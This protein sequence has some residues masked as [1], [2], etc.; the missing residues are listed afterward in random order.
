[1]SFCDAVICTAAA[2]DDD[3]DDAAITGCCH[4]QT[5]CL[6]PLSLYS[7]IIALCVLGAA[8]I[9]RVNGREVFCL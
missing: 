9:R 3:A 1:M 4:I 7:L 5:R 8:V 6:V 2:D